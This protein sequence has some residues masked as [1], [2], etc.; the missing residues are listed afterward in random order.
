MMFETVAL[1]IEGTDKDKYYGSVKWGY[2]MEGTT[3]A[4]K[5]TKMDIE[6][7]SKGTPTAN[8]IEPAKLWNAGKTLGTIQITADPE[9]TVLKGDASGTEKLA[10]DTK[11]KQLD[12]VFWGTDPAIKA[13]VLKTDGTGSGKIVYIKVADV[14]DMGD[15]SARK[16]L[17]IPTP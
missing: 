1:A 6:E 13:E 7:A 2:K 8:F 14:K 5:V 3:A 4:P 11:L 15:G 17:P 16:N 12:T 10:K 9:A